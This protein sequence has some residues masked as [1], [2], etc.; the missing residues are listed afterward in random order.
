M[1]N[2]NGV[3]CQ[4]HPCNSNNSFFATSA[5][6]ECKIAIPKLQRLRKRIG[7]PE[8]SKQGLVGADIS[9]RQKESEI[10]DLALT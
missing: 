4:R 7:Y 5:L 3:L 2:Q 10:P 9:L 1:K 8:P 6:F